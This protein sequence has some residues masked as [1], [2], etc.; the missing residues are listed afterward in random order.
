[1]L[2]K[3]PENLFDA[4]TFVGSCI[5][6]AIGI[7]AGAS[8]PITIVRMGVYNAI[9]LNSTQIAP[10]SAHIASTLEHDGHYSMFEQL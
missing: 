1:M 3:E 8:L 6:L 10:A 7:R 5:Q 9:L 2:Y 4:T